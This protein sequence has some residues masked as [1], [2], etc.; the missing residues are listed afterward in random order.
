MKLQPS[1][2]FTLLTPD[3]T[4][5]NWHGLGNLIRFPSGT[6]IV[7]ARQ[8][9]R[10]TGQGEKGVL[11]KLVTTDAWATWTGPT[12]F[13]TDPT[14][15]ARDPCATV[16]A[17]GRVVVTFFQYDQTGP[18]ALLNGNK[19]LLSDDGGVTWTGP[20]DMHYGFTRWEAQSS[21]PVV[22]GDGTLMQAA[23]GTDG[24]SNASYVKVIRST[25]E[26][27]TWGDLTTVVGADPLA[28]V[29][30]QEP[31]L[32]ALGGQ[33]VVCFIRTQ[34]LS[35]G[36]S[37]AYRTI[38]EDGGRTWS[39]P[40][41]LF[42]AVGSPRTIQLSSGLLLMVNRQGG[43]AHGQLS[44]NEGV[45][46]SA[47]QLVDNSSYASMYYAGL[48][49]RPDGVVSMLVAAAAPGGGLECYLHHKTLNIVG[50]HPRARR[51]TTARTNALGARATLSRSN[52]ATTLTHAEAGATV[53]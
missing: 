36:D 5:P 42:S 43:K 50:A 48:A 1:V 21:P 38:S 22:L 52:A 14:W 16:L 37:F 46:W 9:L 34:I 35:R 41:E 39:T 32:V 19:A 4:E 20:I 17:S 26:G 45:T 8:G 13:Y 47:H 44:A 40:V 2:A 11:E 53:G 29:L 24:V 23:Y 12:T 6:E 15:D 51:A 18:R 31:N 10:E 28:D 25:D 49:E 33:R 30:Y 27:E 7:F 3:T